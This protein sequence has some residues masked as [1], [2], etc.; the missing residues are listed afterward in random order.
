MGVAPLLFSAAQQ[1]FAE[2][3]HLPVNSSY[4]VGWSWREM[5]QGCLRLEK[6]GVS[7]IGQLN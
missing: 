3:P 1:E 2:L 4:P 6:Q 7:D 5:V